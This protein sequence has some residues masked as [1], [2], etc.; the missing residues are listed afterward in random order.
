MRKYH[1]S[2]NFD[3]LSTHQS[4]I[5]LLMSKVVKSHVKVDKQIKM[6]SKVKGDT[7][8][9]VNGININLINK[10]QANHVYT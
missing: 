8:Q 9:D 7:F 2:F 4:I 6:Q 10:F 5:L 3:A 1:P